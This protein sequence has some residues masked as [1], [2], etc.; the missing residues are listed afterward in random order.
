MQ[1]CH[2]ANGISLAAPQPMLS[3]FLLAVLFVCDSFYVLLTSNLCRI[4]L[5]CVIILMLWV[6]L[7]ILFKCVCSR[8]DILLFI[9][10]F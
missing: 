1:C 5:Q 4:A 3:A 9:P 8:T 10:L 6:I 7:V 2:L